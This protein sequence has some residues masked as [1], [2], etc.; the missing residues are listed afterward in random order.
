MLKIFIGYDPNERAAFHTLAYS[1]LRQSSEPVAI[2]P[3]V[4]S[5]LPLR[6]PRDPHQTTEFA[7]SRFLVPHLCN[8]EGYALFLDC[9]ML[10]RVDISEFHSSIWVAESGCRK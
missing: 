8:Y 3:L 4:L 6:R 1:I 7:F 10:C 5:Q 2:T 9:D